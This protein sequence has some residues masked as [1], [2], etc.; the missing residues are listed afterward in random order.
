MNVPRAT[1]T[2]PYDATLSRYANHIMAGEGTCTLMVNGSATALAITVTSGMTGW[3]VDTTHSVSVVQGDTCANWIQG[4][5]VTG[6]TLTWDGA[7]LRVV[8]S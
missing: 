8:A 3:L 7:G 1:G 5:G 6:T 4:S 2:F